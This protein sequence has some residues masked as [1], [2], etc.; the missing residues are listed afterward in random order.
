MA[1]WHNVTKWRRETFVCS[2]LTI[3][4][5]ECCVTMWIHGL[6]T[7]IGLSSST[8]PFRPI[9]LLVSAFTAE[10]AASQNWLHD[11]LLLLLVDCTNSTCWTL[12]EAWSRSSQVVGCSSKKN[13]PKQAKTWFRAKKW[14]SDTNYCVKWSVNFIF[15]TKG[16]YANP[17]GIYAL[18]KCRSTSEIEQ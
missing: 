6:S 3:L 15:L 2:G 18:A 14:T 13:T 8:L 16:S 7:M 9:G 17:T 12:M 10:F 4:R 1:A 5:G 11:L